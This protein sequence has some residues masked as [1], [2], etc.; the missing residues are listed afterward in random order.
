MEEKARNEL[1]QATRRAEVSGEI[2]DIQKRLNE[3]RGNH[4]RSIEFGLETTQDGTRDLYKQVFSKQTENN[5]LRYDDGIDE[6]MVQVLIEN[7]Q[8]LRHRFT[9]TI[10][11]TMEDGEIASEI[12]YAGLPEEIKEEIINSKEITIGQDYGSQELQQALNV[13]GTRIADKYGTAGKTIS[14]PH[15]GGKIKQVILSTEFA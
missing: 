4:P 13:L 8:K 3:Y 1:Q 9:T 15:G 2:K 14:V 6:D 7:R 12:I 10:I 11:I 5:I